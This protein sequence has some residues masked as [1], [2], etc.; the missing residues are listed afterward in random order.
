M[1]KMKIG[2]KTAKEDVIE[3]KGKKAAPPPEIDEE[4]EDIED[5]DDIDLDD[6]DV[7]EDDIKAVLAEEDDEDVSGNEE[8]FAQISAEI[9]DLKKQHAA[10][11]TELVNLLQAL[12]KEILEIK[13]PTVI[14]AVKAEKVKAAIKADPVPDPEEEDIEDDDDEDDDETPAPVVKKGKK[15]VDPL[16]EKAAKLVA[17]FKPG[18]FPLKSVLKTL[19]ENL[20]AGGDTITAEQLATLTGVTVEAGKVTIQR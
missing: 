11:F 4:D 18:T 2:G 1:A 8:L 9:V 16:L 5:E 14:P 13:R 19:G 7:S 20:G 10:K 12:R 6:L 17:R 15:E 3:K